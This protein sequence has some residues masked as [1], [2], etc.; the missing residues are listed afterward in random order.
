MG[1]CTA[2]S[3]SPCYCS[4]RGANIIRSIYG[5]MRIL[6][7]DS[8][9]ILTLSDYD[10]LERLGDMLNSLERARAALSLSVCLF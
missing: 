6:Y 7:R 3:E 9:R 4:A 2:K 1:G 5:T 8:S 10:A